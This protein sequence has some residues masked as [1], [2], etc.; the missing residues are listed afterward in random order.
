M[1]LNAVYS[2]FGELDGMLKKMVGELGESLDKYYQL[3]W[4]KK[5]EDPELL[6]KV[7]KLRDVAIPQLATMRASVDVG[8]V[9]SRCWPFSSF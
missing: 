4:A 3:F 5:E 6:A 1:V 7:L 2:L 9:S 8:L